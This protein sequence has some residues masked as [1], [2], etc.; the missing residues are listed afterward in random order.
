[1]VDINKT[2]K[3]FESYKNIISSSFTKLCKK[4][5]NNYSIYAILFA[6]P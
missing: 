6:H 4:E 3:E 2:K 5:I 1:M